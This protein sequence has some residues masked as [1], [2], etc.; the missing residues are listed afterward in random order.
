MPVKKLNFSISPLNDNPAS[1]NTL[2]NGA[3]SYTNGFS[4]KNGFPTI[5]FSIPA[6]EVL[7]DTSSLHLSGQFLVRSP[8]D[9][10]VSVAS[11][12]K[13]AGYNTL[14]GTTPTFA[15]NLNTSNWNGVAS[16]IDKVVIQ[17]KKTQ[18]ELASVINYSLGD[19]LKM[20]MSA[21]EDDYK[22]GPLVRNLASG[23]NH[24]N[25][26]RH[27]V[28]TPALADTHLT[29]LGSKW[30]GHFFSLKI[31]VALLQA[32]AL[33]LGNGY[34]GGIILTIH[35]APDAAVFHTR[36]RNMDGNQPSAVIAG[37]SYVLKNLKLEGKY[38]LPTKQE[39]KAYNPNVVLNSRVNLMNDIVSTN[40]S[41]V[42][43]PQLSAVKSVVNVFLDDD[44]QNNFNQNSNNFRTPLGLIGYLQ[45]KNNIR[46]P[47]DFR[48]ECVPSP[49]SL[50]ES[51]VA[52]Q[53]TFAT[54]TLA[55][56]AHSVGDSEVR[57]QFM[58]SV[59]GKLPNHHSAKYSL[60][61]RSLADDWNADVTA[62]AA[63]AGG[64]G[65][66]TGPLVNPDLMGIG[67]DYTNGIG[68]SQNYVNQDYELKV[69]SKVNSGTVQQP[70]NRSSKIVIQESFLNNFAQMNLQSLVKQ[71]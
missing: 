64:L 44:Q 22:Q 47:Y 61:C 17:S 34:V 36:H 42:Y 30:V 63:G 16:V 15:N 54:N 12:A 40:N 32:Q 5:K 45:A 8:D 68:Q 2:A 1:T 67:A 66:A 48:T 11:G 62:G 21:N 4:H 70:V 6:Q 31:D 24:G 65:F 43:T 35:L 53:G 29:Q 69:D 51:T 37:S 58:K 41:N 55:T 28:V 20:G 59:L 46:F 60:T 38:M 25:V 56:R 9:A 33:H 52:T 27:L 49:E 18:T 39:Q 57:R 50:T 26:C 19:A 14:N 71:Q 13:A 10:L 3:A 23:E 7:L